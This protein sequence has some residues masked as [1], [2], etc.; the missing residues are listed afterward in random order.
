[1][2]QRSSLIVQGLCIW[3]YALISLLL[4]GAALSIVESDY[5]GAWGFYVYRL[6]CFD[7]FPAWLACALAL[8]VISGLGLFRAFATAKFHRPTY[9]YP[10]HAGVAMPSVVPMIRSAQLF[11]FNLVAVPLLIGVF[12]LVRTMRR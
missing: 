10:T 5:H 7:Y 9:G 8:A 2:I 1:M 6:Y 12:L 4:C 11:A 3:P